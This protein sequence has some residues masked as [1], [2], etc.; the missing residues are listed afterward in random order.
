MYNSYMTNL[1]YLA[2]VLAWIIF[3]LVHGAKPGRSTL[4][5]YELRRLEKEGDKH[6]QSLTRRNKL[7]PGA[8]LLK[9]WLLIIL[10]SLIV[11]LTVTLNG[12]F[13]GVVASVVA[14]ALADIISRWQPLA[15]LAK[16]YWTKLEPHLLLFI[17]NYAKWLVSLGPKEQSNHIAIHSQQEL[18]HVIDSSQVFSPELKSRLQASLAFGESAASDIMLPRAEIETVDQS[19]T[20]GPVILDN[21]HKTGRTYF[22]VIDKNIDHVVGVLHLDKLVGDMQKTHTAKKAMEPR[23]DYVNET[24]PLNEVLE[25][26]LRTGQHLLIVVNKSKKTVGVIDFQTLLE[27]L[28]GHKLADRQNDFSLETQQQSGTK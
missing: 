9:R 18:A 13:L 20:L 14:I 21:L 8:V 7:L 24:Q 4:S 1:I 6:A 25:T 16:K 17:H 22:P 2:D 26:F 12:W 27:K 23:A 19:D 15:G 3:L 28:V 10:A 11:W 5:Q